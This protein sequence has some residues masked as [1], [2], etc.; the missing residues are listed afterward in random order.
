VS[1]KTR[2]CSFRPP[3]LHSSSVPGSARLLAHALWLCGIHLRVVSCFGWESDARD[4]DMSSCTF[5]QL[6]IL[7]ACWFNLG[8]TRMNIQKFFL[9]LT[10]YIYVLWMDFRANNYFHIDHQLSNFYNR[11]GACLL[12]GTSW[13][14]YMLYTIQLTGRDIIVGIA[15]WYGLDGPGIES[16][17][18]WDFPLPSR[19]ALSHSQ[20]AIQR[21]PGHSWG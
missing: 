1:K 10:Q 17:W 16:R 2:S 14:Y 3:F 21:I 12:H 5:R 20:L 8:T 15:T 11:D 13:F 4:I 7:K 9:M 6:Y 18:G 19:L